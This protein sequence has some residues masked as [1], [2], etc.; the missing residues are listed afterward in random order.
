MNTSKRWHVSWIRREHETGDAVPNRGADDEHT[1]DRG[2]TGNGS[3]CGNPQP[4]H[5]E[6]GVVMPAHAPPCEQCVIVDIGRDGGIF[7]CPLHVAA[8]A[9][10]AMV[11]KLAAFSV[12]HPQ[13]KLRV[14]SLKEEAATLLKEIEG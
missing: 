3:D 5:D 14:S 13:V 9:L 10:L 7:F 11:Q 6:L 12:M 1:T 8:P 4:P 2:S